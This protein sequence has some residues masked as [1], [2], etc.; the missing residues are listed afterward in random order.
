[1]GIDAP[2]PTDEDTGYS[3]SAVTPVPWS[4]RA[5]TEVESSVTNSV[6][7]VTQ[8]AQ[9]L[10]HGE[11][12]PGGE[13]YSRS[14]FGQGPT[15]Y[16][17]VPT[18]TL[19]PEEA[20]ARYGVPGYQRFNQ[21]IADYDAEA[22]YQRA[23]RQRYESTV[24]SRSDPHVLGDI[25]AG[26]LGS[27]IDPVN[28]T[29]AGLTWGEAS[30]GRAVFG[31]AARGAEL[32]ATQGIAKVGRIGNG[33]ARAYGQSVVENL[34]FV[35]KDAGLAYATGHPDDFDMGQELAG[36][37]GFATL[38]AGLFAGLNKLKMLGQGAPRVEAPEAPLGETEP[39]VPGPPPEP[40]GGP[41][42]GPSGDFRPEAP[43]PP[44][45]APTVEPGAPPVESERAAAPPEREVPAT[46]SGVS[47]PAEVERLSPDEARGGLAVAIDKAS[48]D[49]SVAPVGKLVVQAADRPELDRLNERSA[50]TEVPS[51]RP[52]GEGTGFGDRAITTRGSE[53]PVKFGLIEAHDLVTS[54]DNEMNRNGAYPAE[55]Q[56]RERE[57]AGSYARNV[58]MEKELNPK[59]LMGDVSAAAG[60]PIVSPGGVVE[61]GNGRT[62]ALR[63]SAETGSPGYQRYLAELQAQGLPVDGMQ[64]PILVRMRT[65]PL[66][67][68]QRAGLAHEMNADVTERMSAPE[69][70][71]A[72]AGKMDGE[73]MAALAGD[74]L[75]SKRAFNRKF[76]ERVAPDQIGDMVD[77]NGHL[78]AAGQRRIDAAMVA[79]AYGD[80]RLVEALFETGEDTLRGIGKALVTAAPDFARLHDS[81]ERGQ[82]PAAFNIRQAI[83]AAV[84]LVRDARDSR[85][86]VGRHLAQLLSAQSMFDGDKI[87][88]ATETLIRLFYRNEE[89]TQVRAAD[90]VAE[91]LREYAQSA[92][93]DEYQGGVDLFGQ[94]ADDD[95]AVAILHRIW[96]RA[97]QGWDNAAG[98]V[99][100]PGGSEGAGGAAE[101][102]RQD[103]RGG[104]APRVQPEGGGLREPGGGG[105]APEGG[106]LR[107]AGGEPGDERAG[108]ADAGTG[109]AAVSG[110][111]AREPGEAGAA[112]G[113]N[114]ATAA[115]V[116]AGDPELQALERDYHETEAEAGR[117]LPFA[118]DNDPAAWAEAARAVG[119]CMKGEL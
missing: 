52:I 74:D 55:L 76:I 28:V 82:A 115:Q 100:P 5:R 12:D 24:L 35:A 70:A 103:V 69:Q 10:T 114:P 116:I 113:I 31:E 90:K 50:I 93:S 21:P 47:R 81:I 78:S 91:A 11:Y 2:I 48:N 25:G 27:I 77:K 99:R 61:S 63:R 38:H 3:G 39:H 57:R 22:D 83:V 64:T 1:M 67:G 68:A 66:S 9:D 43:A 105:A 36:V 95:Q 73:T 94:Q 104:G 7:Q 44:A 42:I 107:G 34:P 23:V 51:W 87:S 98:N 54:H 56:P 85:E 58:Q 40:A 20:N 4:L 29:L 46:P 97:Q 109:G 102:A 14:R 118:P 53:V 119:A 17:Y 96:R 60:A 62:I 15:P 112:A 41:E 89:F 110:E 26:L 111:P 101:P 30:L 79:K 33:V 92:M 65:E 117:P 8:V 71:M 45:A 37:A 13:N 80:Q 106:Q 86:G 18:T 84:S 16:T 49:E 72:D 6:R 108:D 88:E 59:L 19:T 75:G 32:D